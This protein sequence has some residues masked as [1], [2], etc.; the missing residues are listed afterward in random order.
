M[1]TTSTTPLAK[2][3]FDG[4]ASEIKASFNEVGDEIR[5][6]RGE[7]RAVLGAQL[8]VLKANTALLQ[9]I[10]QDLRRNEDRHVT[11]E[12]DRGRFDHRDR[13]FASKL[14]VDLAKLD[15]EA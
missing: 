10:Q 2:A 8:E 4:W 5:A 14:K 3:E 7:M 15:A 13:V 1:P 12:A 9:Q 11:H 6:M